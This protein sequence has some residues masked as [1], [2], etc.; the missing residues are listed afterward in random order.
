MSEEA[1][2]RDVT[3]EPTPNPAPAA[4]TP[5][6][7]P[8]AAATAPAV[9]DTEAAELGRILLESGYTKDRVNELMQ[10]PQALNSL[11]YLVANDPEQFVRLLETSDPK[12]AEALLEKTADIYV[13]RAE[14]RGLISRG[15]GSAAGGRKAAADPNPGL[16]AELEA[17]KSKV[18]QF[19][20]EKQQERN[21][22]A[23][24]QA[25][26]RYNGRVDDLF[27][28]EGVKALGLTKSE[29]RAMR[30]DLDKQLGADQNIV[31]RVTNGNFVDVPHTFKRILED[32]GSD[33]KAAAEAAKGARKGVEGKA[34]AEFSSG[35]Q[36]FMV[37]VPAAAADSWEGTESALASAMERMVQSGGR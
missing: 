29:L 16:T 9:N 18:N 23:L 32:W 15:D 20:T 26:A 25:Q 31:Q 36:P 5:E 33:R 2:L 11:R 12:A 14:D 35:A 37:D 8:A 4:T 1:T 27:N 3:V 7:A 10:A 24:A 34:F 6:P 21:A 17:L 28:S 30:A 19:E 13:K 22:A